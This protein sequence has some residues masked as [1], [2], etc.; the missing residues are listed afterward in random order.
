MTNALF[1]ENPNGL[2]LCGQKCAACSTLSFP[3]NPYGCETCGA[4]ASKLSEH[5]LEARGRLHAFATTHLAPRND[6]AAP[7]TVAVVALDAGPVIRALMAPATDE[8]LSV[9]DRVEAHIIADEQGRSSLRFDR[10]ENA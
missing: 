9:G 5:P 1:L 7:F 2:L 6:L 10:L 4:P 8:G 3:P